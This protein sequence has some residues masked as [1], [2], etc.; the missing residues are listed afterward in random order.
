MQ[1]GFQIFSDKDLV[2]TL[3]I[4]FRVSRDLGCY[5][6]GYETEESER[7]S[8]QHSVAQGFIHQAIVFFML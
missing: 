3:Y 2:I 5:F 7:F 8:E 1:I 6:I 4:L